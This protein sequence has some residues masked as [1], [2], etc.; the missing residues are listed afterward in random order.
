L[1][2]IRSTV[3]LTE[4]DKHADYPG[5]AGASH[6]ISVSST[7]IP[8]FVADAGP[9]KLVGPVELVPCGATEVHE[10]E[11]VAKPSRLVSI[12]TQLLVPERALGVPAPSEESEF[13]ESSREGKRTKTQGRLSSQ[14]FC[15]MERKDTG[16]EACGQTN[17]VLEI[18]SGQSSKETYGTDQLA[19]R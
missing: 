16:D 9:V 5:H 4:K 10:E 13:W 1:E 14:D 3:L 12:A 19:E 11:I 18:I 2:R 17:S 15:R 7:R 6:I 8:G